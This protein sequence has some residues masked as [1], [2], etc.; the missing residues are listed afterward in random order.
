MIS[1]DEHMAARPGV[2]GPGPGPGP[3]QKSNSPW[4]VWHGYEQCERWWV[5]RWRWKEGKKRTIEARVNKQREYLS[6]WKH[7]LK[8]RAEQRIQQMKVCMS[9]AQSSWVSTCSSPKWHSDRDPRVLQL[10]SLIISAHLHRA[11]WQLLQTPCTTVSGSMWWSGETQRWPLAAEAPV[12]S[13]LTTPEK[14][15]V[16]R[17][18][19]CY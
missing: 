4:E 6:G 15:H 9:A 8:H 18:N 14:I 2:M 12:T 1:G 5:Q 16:H 11:P 3:A 19:C 13:W 17:H 7:G 10:L